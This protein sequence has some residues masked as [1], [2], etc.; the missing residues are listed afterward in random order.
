MSAGLMG[1]LEKRRFRNFLI[2]TNDYD[3]KSPGT[4]KGGWREVMM[5]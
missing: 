3:E 4:F 5:V 1:I 2:W